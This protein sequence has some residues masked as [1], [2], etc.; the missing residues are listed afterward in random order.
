MEALLMIN[1]SLTLRRYNECNGTQF[2]MNHV[3][4]ALAAKKRNLRYDAEDDVYHCLDCDETFDTVEQFRME[5]DCEGSVERAEAEFAEIQAYIRNMVKKSKEVNEDKPKQVM[6]KIQ[7]GTVGILETSDNSPV[8]ADE[9]K[10]KQVLSTIKFGTIGVVDTSVNPLVEI[11]T[12]KGN[13]WGNLEKSLESKF[14]RRTDKV[15]VKRRDGCWVYGNTVRKTPPTKKVEAKPHFEFKLAQYDVTTISIGV[16][17]KPSAMESTDQHKVKCATSVR[18]KKRVKTPTCKLNSSQLDMLFRQLSVIMKKRNLQFEVVGSGRTKRATCGF[19]KVGNCKTV[20]VKTLHESGIRRRIDLKLNEFQRMC[21]KKIYKSSIRMVPLNASRIKKGDSGA[22]ILQEHM[23]GKFGRAIDEMFIVRGRYDGEVLNSLSKQTF[24]NAFKMIHYSTSDKFFKPFSE[25]FVANIPQKLDHICESNFNIEDCGT[26]AALITQTIFRFGKITCK[27]CAAN[28]ANLS[29]AEMKEWIR[30]ELD[31]TLENVEKKFSDFKHVIRFLKDLRRLLYLVN[32]NVTTFSDTQQ[33]I[34]SYENEPFTSLK[35]LNETLIKGNLMTPEELNH[36]TTLV[37]KLA[38]FQKNRTDNIRSGD[39]THFRNKMSGKTT[40][41]FS[42]MCDNQ[43]D[44]NGN[45]LWG[46]RGYHAKRFF[47]NYFEIINP[48]EGYDKYQMRKHPYGERTLAIKNLIVSTNLEVLREQLKGEFR[49]QPGLTDQCVSRVNG[50]FAYVCSCV[51]TESGKPIESQFL[52]PTKNH[53]VI[54]NTGDSK[55]VDLPSE[56]SEKMYI[57]KEG[58]CYVNIFLAMLVNVNEESAKDFTKMVRDM[59]IENRLGKWPT[60][61]DVATA[62]HLLT[63]FH[64]ETSNAELPRILVDHNTKTMHVIDSYGS[65]TTGYHVLKANTVSQLIKFADLSLKSEMKF[66]AVGGTAV[67][68]IATQGV[69]FS[70]LIKALYRPKMMELI[71]RDEPYMLVLSV[72]SPSILMALFNSGSLEHATHMWIRK[73]QNIAQIATM[74]SALAGKVTLARTINEQLSIINRHGSSMLENVFR[75]TRPNVSYIQAINVL[76]MIESRGSAN[77][78]LEMHGFQIFPVDLYETME[79]IYQKELDTSWSDLSLCGKLRAMRYSRQWRKY[80]LKTSNLQETRDTKGKYSISLESLRGGTQKFVSTKSAAI[81]QRWNL[82][83]STLKQKVFSKSLSLFVGLL[84]KIFN[85]V[86]TLIVMNLLLSIITQSRRMIYEHRESKQKLAN[87]D[88]DKRVDILEE[89]YDT[90]IAVNKVQ[91]TCE[92]FVEYVQKVNPDIVE[93]AKQVLLNEEESVKHEAKRVSEARLEQAMAFVALILMAIDSERSD[94]VHKVLNKLKSLMSIADADVYHQSIDEIKSEIDEK[95]L[96]IDFALDDTFTPSIREHD[97]TFADWWTNQINNTNVLTHYRTEGKFY[98]FTRQNASEVAYKI[99]SDTSSDFLLR[100]AVG[101]GKSTGL[102]YELSQRG[103][104][105]LI[106][107]TRPL[108]ENVHRQLQGPPFMTNSTLRMRGLSSFGS[109]RVTIMTSGFALHYFANNTDQIAD[110][111][112]VLFDECHVLDSCAMAYRCL[113]H[114]NRFKGKIIKVS[115]TPPGREC[116]FKTQ[117]PVEIRVEE[118]LSFQSFAQ[119]Q[120]TG[121]N[122]D[123]TGDGYNNILVYVASYNEVDSLSKL[124]LDKGY[125]VTKIDG[126]TMKLGNVEIVTNGSEKKKHFLVATNIIENGVTLDIDVVVDFGTKVTPLLDV[127]TR[128]VTYNK[129]SI[130]YGERIQRLGRVGRNKRGLALRI[131]QTQK[132]L[133]EVPPIIATEAAFLC[134]A[135]GLP[136]MTH[137]VSTSL[138]NQCTVKQARVMLNFELSPFYMVNLVRYDGC[139]HPGIHNVL[140]KFKLRDSEI[141]LNSVALPTR[142][143]DTWMSVK[144]YNK[145]GARLSMDD[146]VKIPFL[147]KDIPEKTHEQIWSVMIEHKKDNCFQRISSASACKIAYTLQTDIHAIPRTIAIIDNLIEQERTKESHYSSMKANSATIGSVNIVG[148]VNSIRSRFSQNYAQENIEKLQRAKSQ[149]LEYANLDID[150]S[151]PELVRNFQSLECVTHQSTHGIS[152][153]LQLQGRWNKSVIT[154]DLIVVGGILLGGSY[155]I[156]TWF[157]ESFAMEVYHQGYNKRARQ[158]LKFRNTRDARMAREVFGDDEVIADYFGESYTKKGKQSGRTKGMGSKNRKFVNMYSYDADDFSFVRYVDPLTGYTFDESPM[159]DMRL[160]AEKVMEGRQYELSNGD[161]DWQLVTAKP[162]IKAFYQKGGAKEA[163]MIDLEPHN[164]LEV[165]NTGTIAGYPER[166]DEFRQT[167]KPTVVKVSE[168]PQAN[169]LRE[170]TT[171]EGLSMYKGLRDYNSIASCIC[172]LTNESDGFSESL[173]GIGFGCVIITNQHLFERNNGKLKIQTHHGEFTVPNTTMLQMSPCGNRDI[174]IIKLPKDLPPFPQKLKFRAPKT[175]E[176]I[177][178][179]GT[180]FQEQSTRS[181]VSETSV[182]YPKEGS[183]FWKHWISTKDGYCGLPLVATEDGKIVGIHSLSNVS[184]TQNYFTDFPENFGKD[185]LESLNDLTW[186]KHWRYNSNNIGYGSLMLHKSQPDGI[187]KPIKLIQ[188]LSDES[189]YSQSL[190]NTWLFD[191]LNGNLKAIGKS[192]AQLVTKH[193]VKGKCLLFESYLNTHPEACE[194]FRPL[195]GAYNKS[196]LNKDAYVKDLFKY[197][198][199][200]EVGVLD[201]DTFEKSLEIVIHNMESAGF[202]QC[203]YVTDAQAIFRALNMKAA[204]GALYQGKKR[205]YFK[206]YTD[207][208]K[209]EIV[210]QSCRRLY[211][212]KMGVWNGSLKAELRPIEKVQENKTRSFTAAPIDTLLAGKVCVDD[213][214]NQFYAMHFK[215]PWSV[216]MTKFYGGWD[217]LLSILP[218]GWTY[219]DADGS[220]FDSSLSPYLI[221]AVLQIRLHFMEAF[222]IGEQMLSNLYT[223][224]VYTPILTPD[225]TIV[226]KFKGNNS[227]QPSTVVDNTLMVVLAMTYSLSKL[228]YVGEDQANVCRYL[229][230]GDDLLIALHPE[231]EH[232]AEKLSELFRQLGL[233][234]TFESKTK[235][236]SELWFM[237]HRGIQIDGLYIPKL[238]EERIVSIL[239]WDRSSE[240]EHRL[241]AICAA[242]VESWGY[243]WLT[244]EIRKF[245][246]WVL[247]QEPY[248][249]I[250][251]QGKAPYIAEMALK[252]LYTSKDVSDSELMHFVSEF[253]KMENLYDEDLCVYHQG[254]NV[255][256]AGNGKQDKDK[257]SIV[258]SGSGTEKGQIQPAPDKDINTG[259]SGIYTVPKLKAISNK[260]RVPK[261]KNK[262]SMNL[263]FLLTYLPDQIDISNRRATHSQYDAWFEGVKKDYDVSDAEMEILL[264]G[265]MVWCLEN[266]TSPDLSGTWTMMDGEE[267]KEYPIKPLIEHAKP[268]FRQ[269]M[270]H[271]SDVAVAYIEMRNTKGPYMPGYG[272]KRNLRDR[273]LACYAFDFYEMTSKSPERAKEAHLQMKAASLKNSRTKVFGLDGSVSSKEENTERHTVEDVNRDMHT[274]LGMKGI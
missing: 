210:E 174:V 128:M 156:Y 229:V 269:I 226:K 96:T 145:C 252:K 223:E 152:K 112:F 212:G 16:G 207:E 93:F 111:D 38:R 143:L 235:D 83:T 216:G 37:N 66:Y 175:N 13:V 208:M 80:S 178:M 197:T 256:D 206:E 191:K 78:V 12:T 245:Y 54:G 104:V 100:G 183:T 103:N 15:I 139:M 272:L 162:G 273:S 19:K 64:P 213:F 225:G 26:V 132:G 169:E 171:H 1:N 205:D 254:D 144:S 28:Y 267:Q 92:E 105:L 237:S 141:T 209:D 35:I 136:V 61:M 14:A 97:A 7:F 148:I 168:I 44:K 67:H 74:L 99:S 214:N 164:P 192:N 265:L 153:V 239:E 251:R 266:G 88:F 203:E 70:M 181:T 57:A 40:M 91:P 263:D 236:K 43:L 217:K 215:C 77:E 110:Y 222:D 187:F 30:E 250:A 177:C 248:N 188:D 204:V 240:P 65:K 95:K 219:Y 27:H 34:G 257:K 115:A 20:Y 52:K 202:E 249:E 119:G 261:Y 48:V 195:M 42:L 50:D 142:S 87:S 227:G 264:S 146:S 24:T 158:K 36:A 149:L 5:H 82:I 60:L 137:N 232:I 193:V 253:L 220:Q 68:D 4:R 167:G 94:C 160:V 242:M 69:S 29:D 55:F 59:V 9:E 199:P 63:V 120:G 41:N 268:T 170:E 25:A 117:F 102:P 165:C 173:Y 166:A 79:K 190:N 56:V 151:F 125:L 274:L 211:E 47:S 159:T 18:T 161:L 85:V 163:V 138:L 231:H 154:K 126:R 259:T 53:L 22:L 51:T 84:P 58:Y 241:E 76:T 131:S 238:E 109:A 130:S 201:V 243:E 230:N 184:N 157:R 122:Y 200:I 73:D 2:N 11:P 3:R 62:C 10:P 127:D 39:L 133:V 72:L 189:V 17:L 21:L 113:L 255:L 234:Y 114:D 180:N 116:E 46:Q 233:K 45:F 271:F 106:E 155:M 86:N 135:Y 49:Q 123:V 218:D 247:D 172:K 194:K 89:I 108:A 98:E 179:V 121:C 147:L 23:V 124:L 260:M 118:T 221:N 81:C 6:P 244:H 8:K 228:G 134:F 196:K 32:T 75:G 198:S 186:T 270:H 107:P 258:P 31:D 101:S 90:Y 182:T 140:K 176:R 246:N 33:L 129:G 185:T 262:N 224:I 150:T 71:L